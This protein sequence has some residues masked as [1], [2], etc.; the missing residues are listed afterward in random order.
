MYRL[1]ISIMVLTFSCMAFGHEHMAMNEPAPLGASAAFDSQGGLWTATVRNGH[2]VLHHSS[3]FGKTF[4]AP[5]QV[6]NQAEEIAARAGN[7]PDIAI[8]PQGQ[9]YV[10]W[11][12]PLPERWASE[13]RFAYSTDGGK[14]FSDPVTLNED[15]AAIAHYFA[16]LAVDDK[17]RVIVAW[18]DARNN[19]AAGESD[20]PYHGFT[21]YSR[22]SNDGGK[23]F[24][25]ERKLVEHSC[26]CCRLALDF[27]PDGDAAVLSRMVYP[28]NI[29]DHA[30]TLLHTGGKPA[31]P[32]RVTFSDWQIAACPEQGPG[33]AIDA[34]G[35][36]HAVWFEASHGPAIWYGQL[37]PNHPPRHKLKVGAAGAHHADVAT[38]DGTVW[39]VWN[40]VN[41]EGY[42]LML[43]TS[44]DNGANFDAPRVLASSTNAVYAPQL[45]V[46]DGH[47]Y[48]A[49]NTAD[50][51]HLIAAQQKPVVSPTPLSGADVPELLAPP[52]QGK[53]IIAIWSLGCVYCEPNLAALAE[54]QRAHPRKLQLVTV[55]LDNIAQRSEIAARL[56]RIKMA[57]YPA[58]AY[59]AMDPAHTNYQIAPNWG[60]ATPFTIVIGA[61]GSRTDYV[62]KL[63]A[64]QLQRI[65]SD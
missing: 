56:S 7:H 24:A 3:D 4:G 23:T 14:T 32:E 17:G 29:R 33:L 65:A 1:L 31:K 2:V 43:R 48:A 30:L 42:Q 38:H 51:F 54:L 47:A 49:W 19:K 26:E 58:R 8:G 21:V 45:L 63:T 64:T 15:H 39:I 18:I 57:D 36:H 13:V 55:A 11:A 20:A 22:W 40:Q 6:N 28:G 5:V 50:G 61:D 62:G 59:A 37:D 34:G 16:A 27:L 35:E 44:H 41:A 10:T 60:G 25:T 9:I 52:A 12:H 46:H 53:R